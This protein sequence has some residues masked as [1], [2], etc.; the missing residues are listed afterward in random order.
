MVLT[1]QYSDFN[2]SSALSNLLIQQIY[3][4][5]DSLFLMFTKRDQMLFSM[6]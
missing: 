4:L 3:L 5:I 6:R 1:M 2:G